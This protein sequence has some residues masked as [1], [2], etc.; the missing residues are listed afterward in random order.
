MK[1]ISGF[2]IVLTMLVTFAAC[3]DSGSNNNTT[4]SAGI[5]SS[6]TDTTM[7]NNN[8]T[9]TSSLN[10]GDTSTRTNPNTGGSQDSVR[11]R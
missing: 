5:N 1:R 11:Q 7:N 2:A 10:S 4:D 9:D 6:G 8:M 3:G